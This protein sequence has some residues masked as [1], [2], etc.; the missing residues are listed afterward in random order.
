MDYHEY[1]CVYYRCVIYTRTCFGF[2][3]FFFHFFFCI[4]RRNL[5]PVAPPRS[6][7]IPHAI[8]S[9]RPNTPVVRDAISSCAPLGQLTSALHTDPANRRLITSHTRRLVRTGH[10]YTVY[11]LRSNTKHVRIPLAH[12]LLFYG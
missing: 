1:S 9:P 10:I 7:G 8:P 3:P 11:T 6:V 12:R 5:P 4:I 2:V